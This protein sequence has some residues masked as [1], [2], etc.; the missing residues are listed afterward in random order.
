MLSYIIIYD[1]I[2]III[3]IN[4]A[5]MIIE[6][7]TKY[8]FGKSCWRTLAEGLEREWMITNGIGGSSACTVINNSARVHTGYLVASLNPPVDRINVL[9]KVQ[10][11]V[12][13]GERSFNLAC[14]QF[15]CGEN[16]GY[17]YLEQF[18]LDI[19]PTYCYQTDEISI[20]KTIAMEYG[21]NTVAICY[22]VSGATEPVTVR[23]TPLFAMR[24][25]DRTNAPDDIRRFSSYV[26]DRVLYVN[27]NDD[28]RC[29]AKC[30]ISEGEF[31]DRSLIPT[32]MAAPTF[33]A[34]EN[35]FLAI[36]TRN[37]F[38]GLDSQYTPY[39]AV[40]NVGANET[41]KFFI[42]C[43]TEEEDISAKDGFDIVNAY[44][45]RMRTLIKMNPNQDSLSQKLTWAADAFIVDR[46]STKLK[47]I[48]A[49]MPWFTD[50]ARDTMIA[51]TG[52]TLCTRRFDDC[53]KILKSFAMYEKNGLI[54]NVFPS[55]ANEQPGYNTMDGSLWYFY[56]VERYLK[57]TSGEK[58]YEF[59]KNEIFPVLKKI[60][61]AYEHGTDFSIGMD[62]DGLVHGGSE[63]D[64]ITWMD[65]RVGDWVVT[66]RHGK[67]V[68]INALWYNALKVMEMLC[69][70]FGEDGS[71]Y[72]ELSERVKKSFVQKFWNEKGGYLYDVADPCEDRIRPN[73]IYAVSLP[74][75]MLDRD[76]EIAIVNCVSKHLYTTYGLRSL[77]YTDSEYKSQY[78]GKLINRDGAYHMGTSWAFPMGGY[79]TAYCKVHDYSPDAIKRANDICHRF[80][81]HMRDGCINGIAEIFDGTFTCTSRGCFTQAWSVGEI[82]RAYTED[83][84]PYINK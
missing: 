17:K 68:E 4:L 49:G 66:P 39:D 11:A 48:L 63:L 29:T 31:F 78:I 37:G 23:V 1:I 5:R 8:T 65:V 58:N 57:Y 52:L 77:S 51:M 74:Y 30:Y 70:K 32:S 25:I 7:H 2:L 21:R 46:K 3:K 40:I 75:T 27:R 16:D 61:Y 59:I 10:E 71:H 81:D 42:I 24:A 82:L 22:T 47:T 12:T 13:A 38:N 9:S 73:Q 62:A 54:P 36:D 50:W 34:E 72:T 19:V 41:K 53:E 43:S 67:P 60:Q 26:D 35:Q 15:L 44:I 84:L 45:D 20:E 80:A 28:E 33:I 83:V 56:A 6:M 18:R 64:Q 55:T 14:Q 79:V 69:E 76:K